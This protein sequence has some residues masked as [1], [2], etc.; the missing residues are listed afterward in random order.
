MER[1]AKAT[2]RR[3]AGHLRIQPDLVGKLKRRVQDPALSHAEVLK[4]HPASVPTRLA[5]ETD[6]EGLDE[7][8][9]RAAQR[10]QMEE[11]V[12]E[13]AKAKIT[14]SSQAPEDENDQEVKRQRLG[15]PLASSPEDM[16]GE[17][18]S[19]FTM[20]DTGRLVHEEA[21]KEGR[22]DRKTARDSEELSSGSNGPKR[23]ITGCLRV[24]SVNAL[25]V[26]PQGV[27]RVPRQVAR[28]TANTCLTLAL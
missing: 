25:Q 13:R 2:V 15:A 1:V 7:E 28:N 3:V 18:A 11:I 10:E 5:G 9:D 16:V 14:R 19:D 20:D 24:S 12:N 26:S 23:L 4:V 22:V 21:R 17:E 8:Q 6:T 27:K